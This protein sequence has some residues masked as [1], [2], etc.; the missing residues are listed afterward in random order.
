MSKKGVEPLLPPQIPRIKQELGFEPDARLTNAVVPLCEEIRRRLLEGIMP[1]QEAIDELKERAGVEGSPRRMNVTEIVE[2][3]GTKPPTRDV[4]IAAI[5]QRIYRGLIGKELDS[6]VVLKAL[7]ITDVVRQLGVDPT[8]VL[9]LVPIDSQGLRRAIRYGL[10]IPLAHFDENPHPSGDVTLLSKESYKSIAV[11]LQ[12]PLVE[13]IA[14]IVENEDGT[15]NRAAVIELYKKTLNKLGL[16]GA[17]GQTVFNGHQPCANATGLTPNDL[18][19]L[20][21]TT[22]DGI[23]HHTAGKI[24]R[25]C[26][27]PDLMDVHV[28]TGKLIPPQLSNIKSILH[29]PNVTNLPGVI[30]PLSR[31]IQRRLQAG[32]VPHQEVVNQLIEELGGEG[33]KYAKEILKALEQL[34]MAPKEGGTTYSS[35][36]IEAN[37][38]NGVSGRSQESL[39]KAL[40]IRDVVRQLSLDPTKVLERVPVD[41]KRLKAA[42]HYGL[43]MTLNEFGAVKDPGQ[44]TTFLSADQ[45]RQIAP[46]LYDPQVE[47]ITDVVHGANGVDHSTIVA[48]FLTH[49]LVVRGFCSPQEGMEIRP[50]SGTKIESETGVPMRSLRKFYDGSYSTLSG[51]YV[52]QVMRWCMAQGDNLAA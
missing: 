23:S 2:A 5:R 50:G 19:R 42:I 28:E 21:C 3:W 43:G 26:L 7:T 33:S 12:D 27:K 39:M 17:T 16:I 20:M 46:H 22:P 52:G 29:L 45:Y 9:D 40:V 25:W 15:V 35:K 38:R 37:L 44:F 24:V 18:S 10:G 1:S 34:R 41:T 47:E 48:A 11:H 32:V 6:E 31:E 36:G 14:A 30:V 8:E 49:T 51:R 4:K 13:E